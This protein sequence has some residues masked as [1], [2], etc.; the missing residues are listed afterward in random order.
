MRISTPFC[1]KQMNFSVFYNLK[2]WHEKFSLN[3]NVSGMDRD[4]ELT[5][6]TPQ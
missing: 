4:L 6:L 2:D 5:Q 3:I 1:T